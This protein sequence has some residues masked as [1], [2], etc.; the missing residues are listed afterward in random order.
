MATPFATAT[1]IAQSIRELSLIHTRRCRR[2]ESL[3][4]R[5]APQQLKKQSVK[6]ALT[7]EHSNE[8]QSPPRSIA[9]L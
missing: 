2:I 6:Q 5:R 1:P 3:E 9:L 8:Q 7:I 4:P